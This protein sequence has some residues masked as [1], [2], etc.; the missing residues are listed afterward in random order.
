MTGNPTIDVPSIRR[1]KPLS[2]APKAVRDRLYRRRFNRSRQV[3]LVEVCP[4][5]IGNL[6]A[7]G[8][9]LEGRSADR[10][11]IAKAIEILLDSATPIR[12]AK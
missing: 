9:L 6:I 8:L 7:G 2:K 4:R 10:S 11:A 12:L 5:R 3:V 1:K